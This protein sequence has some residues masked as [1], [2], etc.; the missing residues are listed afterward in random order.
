MSFQ[1]PGRVLLEHLKCARDSDLSRMP[2]AHSKLVGLLD[3]VNGYDSKVG[4]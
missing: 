4:K 2:G 3:G 1:N